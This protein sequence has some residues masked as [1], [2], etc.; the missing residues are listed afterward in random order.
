MKRGSSFRFTE[1]PMPHTSVAMAQILLG[2]CTTP[3]PACWRQGRLLAC[4]HGAR[5]GRL[6]LRGGKL[7]RFDDVDI[8]RAAAEVP[9][10]GRAD[11]FFRR[12]GVMVQQPV[13]GHEH[14]RRTIAALE[15]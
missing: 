2:V 3:L 6:Q 12:V 8:T 15:A 1:W 9:R 14:T 4:R 13:P 7:D 5:L 11:L 10:D